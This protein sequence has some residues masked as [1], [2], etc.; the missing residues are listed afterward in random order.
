MSV[1]SLMSMSVQTCAQQCT[2]V[3]F[4]GIA[5]CCSVAAPVG[6]PRMMQ[7]ML[8]KRS[9]RSITSSSTSNSGRP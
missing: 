6:L 1:Q 5:D 4:A 2:H 7:H 3:I 9:S 8:L